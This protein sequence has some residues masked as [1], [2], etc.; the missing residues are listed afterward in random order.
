MR[1]LTNWHFYCGHPQARRILLIQNIA[2]RLKWKYY[3]LLAT[4]GRCCGFCWNA[5]HRG[6]GVREASL[7]KMQGVF[8]HSQCIALHCIA[9]QWCFPYG[10]CP[11]PWTFSIWYFQKDDDEQRDSGPM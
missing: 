9:S 10:H 4:C 1:K 3:N 7:K 11:I 2:E 8:G 5:S 6:H